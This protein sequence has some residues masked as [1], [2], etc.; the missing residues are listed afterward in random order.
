[1]SGHKCH[2]S[3]TV[4]ITAP[5]YVIPLF[6]MHFAVRSEAPQTVS[7]KSTENRSTHKGYTGVLIQCI[8]P[9]RVIVKG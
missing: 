5:L 6:G 9:I 2:S 1:M 4:I 3:H 7:K 8:Q